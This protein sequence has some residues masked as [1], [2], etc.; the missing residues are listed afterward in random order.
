[1]MQHKAVR[2]PFYRG[3]RKK[4]GEWIYGS[5]LVVNG[6]GSKPCYAIFEYDENGNDSEIEPQT[7]GQFTGLYDKSKLEIF[8]GDIIR[9]TSVDD[10]KYGLVCWDN[11]SAGFAIKLP[12]GCLDYFGKK[13]ALNCDIVGNIHDTPEFIG[14]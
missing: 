14:L 4:S 8:E 10:V 2:T 5:C 3:K 12:D 6:K 1:M 13:V 9:Y 7:L 11:N